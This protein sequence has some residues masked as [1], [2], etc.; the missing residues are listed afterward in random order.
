VLERLRK[1]EALGPR[2]MPTEQMKKLAAGKGFN[3]A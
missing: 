2:F 3:G 1:Y